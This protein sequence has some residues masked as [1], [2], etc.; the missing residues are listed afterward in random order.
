MPQSIRIE[1]LPSQ[2]QSECSCN[3]H[4][5]RLRL[6]KAARC[7]S[8]HGWL[9]PVASDMPDYAQDIARLRLVGCLRLK[10]PPQYTINN[11]SYNTDPIEKTGFTRKYRQASLRMGIE[12]ELSSVHRQD[13]VRA[14][15]SFTEQYARLN[16]AYMRSFKKEARAYCIAK[17]DGSIP[18][19]GT[20][21]S[22]IPATLETHLRCW[23][24][25]DWAEFNDNE[26]CGLH[27]HIDRRDLSPLL[28]GKLS[29]FWNIAASSG[30]QSEVFRRGCN[31]YCTP[32]PVEGIQTP[33]QR[34]GWQDRPRT[35]G[36]GTYWGINRRR[37]RRTNAVSH[38]RKTVELRLPKSPSST[39]DLSQAL[40][41]IECSVEFLRFY[42][43]AA[44][45]IANH[46][47]MWKDFVAFGDAHS[48]LPEKHQD[49]RLGAWRNTIAN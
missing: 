5:A 27:V 29:L 31:D 11:W 22:C 4:P 10:D 32:G 9:Y 16:N 38:R 2:D 17:H 7:E 21:F 25:T 47:G 6:A 8:C 24:S 23:G 28:V 39:Q 34:Q 37:F 1:E 3:G 44:I 43:I 26:E 30:H 48:N 41:C 46:E 18:G 14:S 40:S 12:V 15:Y 49:K 19:T 45:D 35:S 42:S 33:F 20:E 36:R 13:F